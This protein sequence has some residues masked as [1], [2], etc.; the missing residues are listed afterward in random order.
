M[1]RPKIEDTVTRNT[2]VRVYQKRTEKQQSDTGAGSQIINAQH[3]RSQNETT[4]WYNTEVS[5]V[6]SNPSDFSNRRSHSPPFQRKLPESVFGPD[7]LSKKCRVE[8][9]APP[10][11]VKQQFTDVLQA[12]FEKHRK[13]Y[14]P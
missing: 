8:D 3:D 2:T 10:K 14:N 9:G 12:A 13:R 5:R 4:K 7:F 11:D 1:K 6:P